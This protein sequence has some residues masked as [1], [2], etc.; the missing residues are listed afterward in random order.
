MKLTYRKLIAFLLVFTFLVS[1]VS[2]FSPWEKENGGEDTGIVTIS[3]GGE[4]SRSII[5][6]PPNNSTDFDHDKLVIT[7]RFSSSAGTHPPRRLTPGTN[8]QV[9]LNVGTWTISVIALYDDEPYADGSASINVRATGPNNAIISLSP[10][11][12]VEDLLDTNHKVLL[13]NNNTGE[14]ESF[15]NF[16]IV[17]GVDGAFSSISNKPGS[18]T[19]WLFDEQ[20]FGGGII[21]PYFDI[22]LRTQDPNGASIKFTG[23]IGTS[24]LFE[25]HPDA[26]LTLTNGVSLVGNNDSTMAL[27]LLQDGTFNMTG[28]EITGNTNS[29]NGGGVIA[30]NGLFHMSG[31]SIHGNETTDQGGGVSIAGGEFRMTGGTISGN[32]A[33][34]DGGGGVCLHNGVFNM[35][36]GTISGNNTVT[37]GAGTLGRNGGGVLVRDGTFTMSG[38]TISGNTAG[39]ATSGR[40]GGGVYIAGGNFFMDG[41]NISNN[42]AGTETAGGK[43]GG[44]YVNAGLLHMEGGTISG[45]TAHVSNPQSLYR[46]GGDGGGVYAYDGTITMQGGSITNN[47]AGGYGGGIFVLVERTSG[48]SPPFSA[49]FPP[50]IFTK[51]AVNISGNQ[52]TLAVTNHNNTGEGGGNIVGD[53]PGH[54]AAARFF[55]N[56][57]QYNGEFQFRNSDAGP[58]DSMSSQRGTAGGWE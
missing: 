40:D 1:I 8:T 48:N 43:G 17:G 37:V 10:S 29:G 44:V 7:A 31:G 3:L 42:N 26:T 36:G 22:T 54:Q 51:G 35:E 41:G 20:N 39:T 11:F 23:T 50:A 33:E 57:D 49:V 45:N 24:I 55:W 58:G 4:T 38:G 47:K 6:P 21:F 28:G 34:G 46:V 32:T 15:L 12:D 53:P 25:I 13:V 19:F 5:Y 9:T 27:V 14:F 18:Y 16:D 2:C 52:S 56:S 30:N